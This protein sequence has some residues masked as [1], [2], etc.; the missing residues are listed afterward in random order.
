M[1]DN[2]GVITSM[3]HGQEK[4]AIK[5]NNVA[6]GS[7]E[8][9]AELPARD[10][11]GAPLGKRR[12]FQ[13]FKSWYIN[14]HASRKQFLENRRALFRNALKQRARSKHGFEIP[15]IWADDLD[16]EDYEDDCAL[17]EAQDYADEKSW[18]IDRWEALGWYSNK[19]LEDDDK[20]MRVMEHKARR[21]L[22]ERNAGI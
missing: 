6:I 15:D 7:A 5:T 10:R 2:V 22:I 19:K 4:V 12:T 18:Y 21:K 3:N 9:V 11:R 1:T 13:E 14:D 8:A 17:Q 16:L 20:I